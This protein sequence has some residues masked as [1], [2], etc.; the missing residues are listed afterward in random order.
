MFL[1][2]KIHFLYIH[3]MPRVVALITARANTGASMQVTKSL[4]HAHAGFYPA[5]AIF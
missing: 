1:Y 4:A 3:N 2:F 5:Q